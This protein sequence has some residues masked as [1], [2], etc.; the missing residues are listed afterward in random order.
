[1]G[2]PVEYPHAACQTLDGG[3]VFLRGLPNR[4][5]VNPY[6]WT[7]RNMPLTPEQRAELEELGPATVRIKLI[8]P[9]PGKGAALFGFKSEGGLLTRG[10][11]EDWLA[12]KHI[13]ELTVQSNTLRW[14]KIAGWA[15]I[16]SVIA[17]VLIGLVSIGVTVWLAR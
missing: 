16:V 12:E 5:H 8:Q 14:A 6:A 4:D 2:V 17:T 7:N 11:V 9:G 13:E 1:V 3:G 10:D 15:G